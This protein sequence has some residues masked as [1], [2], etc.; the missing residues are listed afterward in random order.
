M[1]LVDGENSV[2]HFV[3]KLLGKDTRR[4]QGEPPNGIERRR[5]RQLDQQLQA[6]QKTTDDLVKEIER[7]NR[8]QQKAH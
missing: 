6:L 8:R 5:D 4:H 7:V 3:Y 1:N 2:M